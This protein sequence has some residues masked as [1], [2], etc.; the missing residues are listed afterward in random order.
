MKIGATAKMTNTVTLAVALLLAVE[1]TLWQQFQKI[2]IVFNK[3]I[4]LL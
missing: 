1:I 2:L 4:D 3:S